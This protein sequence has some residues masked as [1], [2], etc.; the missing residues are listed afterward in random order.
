MADRQE[1][2]IRGSFVVVWLASYGSGTTGKIISA[3]FLNLLSFWKVLLL[4]DTQEKT[5]ILGE[6]TKLL[7]VSYLLIVDNCQNTVSKLFLKD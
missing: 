2:Q 3:K 5:H 1:P 4:A 7:S 6:H